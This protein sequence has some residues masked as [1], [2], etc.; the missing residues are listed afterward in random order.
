MPVGGADDPTIRPAVLMPVIDAMPDDVFGYLRAYNPKTIPETKRE[1]VAAFVRDA[2]AA[3][4]P[5]N[6]FTVE[7][8]AAPI[9]RLVN[10]AHIANGLPMRYVVLF[11]PAIIDRF[12]TEA[13]AS[14]ELSAGSARNYRAHLARV[15]LALGV[16]VSASP[17]P[18]HR[19]DRAKPYDEKELDGWRLWARTRPTA[20]SKTR[21]DV[22]LALMAG[23]GLRRGELLSLQSRHVI[24][25]DQ[26]VWIRVSGEAGR[27]VPL[28][29]QWRNRLLRHTG[30]LALGD[31]VYPAGR[32]AEAVTKSMKGAAAAPEPRRLR[33]SWLV[34][35]LA[36]GTSAE[37]LLAWSGVE[38]GETLAGYLQY[39]P[40]PINEIRRRSLLRTRAVE[41]APTSALRLW[42]MPR[43]DV[44]GGA[45]RERG[46]T[47]P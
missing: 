8:A 27:V 10:W 22:T 32:T 20:L 25:D 4:A 24:V 11:A 3:T 6:T 19:T 43:I 17:A 42:E 40:G 18:I 34:A 16:Q 21:A 2:V 41:A 5:L 29:P 31:L 44:P 14:G 30:A 1:L 39:L 46:G 47:A 35:Q 28:L 9:V 45:N 33:A 13:A 7:Q 26:E 12:L 37:H 23:A 15:A 36:A 38:R